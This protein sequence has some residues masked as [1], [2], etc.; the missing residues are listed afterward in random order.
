M[1]TFR[2]F[3]LFGLEVL[4]DEVIVLLPLGIVL[5]ILLAAIV[6]LLLILERA[7]SFRDLA[8]ANKIGSEESG[9]STTLSMI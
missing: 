6:F 8:A 4:L 2:F 9:V 5:S 7:I 1:F 3:T